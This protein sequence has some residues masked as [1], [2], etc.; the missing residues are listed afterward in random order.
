MSTTEQAP[1]SSSPPPSEQQQQQPIRVKVTD[2]LYEVQSRKAILSSFSN[3]HS[4]FVT[5]TQ[6]EV[7]PQQRDEEVARENEQLRQNGQQPWEWLTNEW[8]HLGSDAW[9]YA[10]KWNS[11]I[12]DESKHWSYAES[13][14]DMVRRRKWIRTRV[15]ILTV[16]QFNGTCTG[17]FCLLSVL[18]NRKT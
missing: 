1:A 2:I 12:R 7:S 15:N 16:Q 11:V 5:N 13:F 17:L 18:K 9:Q 14:Y 4:K 3:D 10:V 8:Q 6:R